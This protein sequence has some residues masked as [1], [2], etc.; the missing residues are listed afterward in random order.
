MVLPLTWRS[1]PWLS[2]CQSMDVRKSVCSDDY[3]ASLICVCAERSNDRSLRVIVC[4][5]S[6]LSEY[7]LCSIWH[8]AKIVLFVDKLWFIVFCLCDA[9]CDGKIPDNSFKIGYES[10]E[11]NIWFFF[12]IYFFFSRKIK[13]NHE[14][15]SYFLIKTQKY[16]ILSL[17]YTWLD[18]DIMRKRR[19]SP[20][21]RRYMPWLS[22]CLQRHTRLS[23]RRGR[24][25]GDWEP[26][27]PWYRMSWLLYVLLYILLCIKLKKRGWKTTR[28]IYT[29]NSNSAHWSFMKII[30]YREALAFSMAYRVCA[31]YYSIYV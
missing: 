9:G 8:S 12:W 22:V 11:D 19:Y 21:S 29:Y 28:H 15:T 27:W 18:G 7:W 31:L 30:A 17:A 25:K 14:N 24:M 16:T 23:E 1:E 13:K 3:G 2:P 4:F 10:R 5:V 26:F 20:L 6:E